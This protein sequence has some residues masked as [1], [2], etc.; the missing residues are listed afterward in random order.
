M[1]AVAWAAPDDLR[2]PAEAR[3]RVMAAVAQSGVVRPPRSVA[4]RPTMPTLAAHR[5]RVGALPQWNTRLITGL[6]AAAGIALL[7]GAVFAGREI[8]TQRDVALERAHAYADVVAITDEALRD[9]DH[10]LATL[11]DPGGTAVG[12]VLYSPAHQEVVMVAGALPALAAEERYRCFVQRDGR[13]T[14]IGW[15]WTDEDLSYWAG[16]VQGVED[17]GRAGDTVIVSADPDGGDPVL[18]ANF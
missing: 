11:S 6:A 7:V 10:R 12:T 9:P 15:M 3:G 4:D 17:L 5:R 13:L 8:A 2:A 14:P 1:G 18:I 16:R